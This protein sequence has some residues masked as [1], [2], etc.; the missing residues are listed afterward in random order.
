MKKVRQLVFTAATLV[1]LSGLA[2][3]EN[4]DSSIDE[5]V[6]TSTSTDGNMDSSAGGATG[7]ETDMGMENPPS[8]G[9]DVESGDYPGGS[10]GGVMGNYSSATNGDSSMPTSGGFGE[11]N[12]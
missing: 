12:P 11:T 8:T 7:S 2:Y 4:T 6:G 1:A 5:Q 3:S 9:G 10:P